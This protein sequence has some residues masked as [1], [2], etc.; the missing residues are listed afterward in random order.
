[1]STSTTSSRERGNRAGRHDQLES[2]GFYTAAE[3]ARIA[4]IPRQRLA[5][6]RREAIVV[7][8]IQTV[9]LDGVERTG[10]SFE[11][12]VYL[13]LLRM[14]R[15]RGLALEKAVRTIKHLRDR[16]GP[17]GPA[18][19]QAR[20]FVQGGDLFADAADQWD[21]TV[22]TR[23]GQQAATVLFGDEFA[24]L[25]ERA[26]ALLV[27]E[28]FRDQVEIDPAV[29]SGLPVVRGTT[30]RTSVIHDLAQRGLDVQHIREYYPHLTPSQVQGALAYERFL[31]DAA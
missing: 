30:I 20:I 2:V 13:R 23:G 8:T 18:W 22:A 31:D 5:A 16:F 4:Q 29:H 28:Q 12:V 10:Y 14:M 21:V 19:G 26:D 24:Q 6:W 9:D 27:P 17:P 3:A 7:P 15:E 1:M 25:R 11:A